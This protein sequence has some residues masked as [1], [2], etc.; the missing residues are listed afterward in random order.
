ML[1][2]FLPETRRSLGGALGRAMGR[3]GAKVAV[4]FALGL[5]GLGSARTW[6]RVPS[7]DPDVV[8]YNQR[9]LRNFER[10]DF[11]GAQR[12]LTEALTRDAGQPL[13]RFNWATN[14]LFGAVKPGAKPDAPAQIDSRALDDAIRE[15]EALEKEAGA[16]GSPVFRQILSYQKA[17]ALELKQEIP[18]ALEAY[19]RSV[20]TAG[21]AALRTRAKNNIQ[22]LL[23]ASQ[24]GGGGGGNDQNQKQDSQGG[25]GDQKDQKP[26]DKQDPGAGK[27]PNPQYSEGHGQGQPKPKFAAGELSETEARQILQSVSGEEREVLKR[28]AQDEARTRSRERGNQEGNA[29]GQGKQW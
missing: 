21:D 22:R 9:A 17:Q 11:A 2:F 23:V 26:G 12:D 28:K 20:N 3:G 7:A 8:F 15:F 19:Y 24:G 18:K 16:R 13:V 25:Q 29:A 14:K 4:L 27:K 5:A 1:D 6:A 10:K